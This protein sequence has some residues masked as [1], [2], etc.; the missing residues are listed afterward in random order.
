[1]KNFKSFL[2]NCGTI[3]LSIL[4]IVFLSQGYVKWTA[5]GRDYYTSGFKYIDFS[6]TDTRR[7]MTAF[8]NVFVLILAMLLIIF[9]FVSL[10]KDCGA[11]KM[12]KKANKVIACFEAILAVITLIF[13]TVALGCLASIVGELG[14]T[15]GLGWA[16][17]ANLIVSVL[18]LVL[19]FM[20][21][22]NANKRK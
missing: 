11:V 6:S 7:D 21:V 10:L 12:S 9:A 15:W 18:I 14:A 19:S 4:T 20:S 1:M 22:V 16:V 3:I 13:T 17:I 2:I 5:L 8:A